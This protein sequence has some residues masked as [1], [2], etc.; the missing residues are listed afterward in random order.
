[1]K[2]FWVFDYVY[3]GDSYHKTGPYKKEAKLYKKAEQD[4]PDNPQLTGRQALLSL[5]LGDTVAANG[6]LKKFLASAKSMSIPEAFV[7]A[8]LADLYNEAGVLV[9]A[10]EYYRQAFSLD[11]ANS[12]RVNDLAYFLIDKDRNIN[13]A[14]DLIDRKLDLSPENFY[15]LHTKGFGLYKQGKYQEA[16]GIFQKSSVYE[17]RKQ[18]M[19]MKPISISRLQ[20]RL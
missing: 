20:K 11:S 15:L 17:G 9:K 5:I 2:P 1:M 8:L 7:A 16:L 3:L 18:S 19:T 4:F 10:E 12:D 13:E 14:L 6:Y